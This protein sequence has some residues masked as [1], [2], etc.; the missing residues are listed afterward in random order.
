VQ[1]WEYLTAN[2]NTANPPYTYAIEGDATARWL[3]G[4]TLS[5]ELGRDG[6][7]LS[8]GVTQGG[9]TTMLIFK[10]PV[11]ETEGENTRRIDPSELRPPVPDA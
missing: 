3:T 8:T 5:T 4:S 1:Q 10:R 2:L 6:W 9:Y 7:E 11:G